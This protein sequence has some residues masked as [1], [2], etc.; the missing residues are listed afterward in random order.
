MRDNTSLVPGVA[1]LAAGVFLVSSIFL[2]PGFA[3]AQP[4]SDVGAVPAPLAKTRPPQDAGASCSCP[5]DASK[6]A[7]PKFAGLSAG[8]LDEA[9]EV[10]ALASVHQAL[11]G[12]GDGQSYVWQRTNGR[13]SGLVQPVS[14]FR[15][16]D[17]QICRHV[18]ILLTTGAHT[19]K[20]EGTACRL[21]GGRW[22][23]GG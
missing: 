17:G 21:P 3:R 19:R 4:A 6:P 23:L 15:N 12:V 13:L 1:L 7:R 16:G 2:S 5:S 10:A 11:S 18:V 8:P 20:N 22:Q 9:D 14:S